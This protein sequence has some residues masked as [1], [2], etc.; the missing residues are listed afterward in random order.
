[1]APERLFSNRRRQPT[2]AW[3]LVTVLVLRPPVGV[4]PASR[5]TAR[6]QR[7]VIRPRREQ[8]HDRRFRV[9]LAPN[10]RAQA[11]ARGFAR[12]WSYRHTLPP[13]VIA[14]MELVVAEL[15]S[16]AVRHGRPPYALTLT[17]THGVIRGEVSDAST[18]SPVVNPCPDEH[19]GF[20]LGIVEAC[21][22]RW[23]ADVGADG[24]HVWFEVT[25]L[26]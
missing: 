15:V 22:S 23:G 25:P 8:A 20:G 3:S 2:G 26:A 5:F 18:V 24:K 11:Q 14:D 17:Q 12:S 1:V 7:V 19:G 13:P 6:P 21:T 16:N 9:R 10:E 4:L